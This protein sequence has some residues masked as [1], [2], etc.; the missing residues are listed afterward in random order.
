MRKY[1]HG[2]LKIMSLNGSKFEHHRVGKNLKHFNFVYKDPSD[3][4][5][6]EKTHIKDLGVYISNNLTWKRQVDEVVSKARAMTGW[7]LRTFSTREKVPLMTLWMSQVRPILDYCSALWSPEP[8]N[9]K[10]IDVLEDSLRT[11]TRQ[12]NGMEGLDYAQRLKALG[13]Y[14]VQRRHERYKIIYAYK[15][16]EGLVENLSDAYGL[17]FTYYGRH[18]CRCTM[19][20]FP[21]YNNKVKKARTNSFALTACNL[22]N[23]LPKHIRNISGKNIEYFK[24]TLDNTLK[25]YPDIPRCSAVGL[26]RDIHGRKSNS[27]YHILKDKEIKKIA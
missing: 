15:I 9:F 2:L 19:P 11:F 13:L 12:I 20:T 18:G 17:N 7:I 10:E 27:L 16:K 26:Y 14:S 25:Q 8:S 23:S 5:I 22:W 1:I 6:N 21:L 3:N 24:K 4:V